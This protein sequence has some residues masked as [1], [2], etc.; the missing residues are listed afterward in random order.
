VRSTRNV[1]EALVYPM[2]IAALGTPLSMWP[3]YTY[4]W[5]T[6]A[7]LPS[8]VKC[9]PPAICI[10]RPVADTMMSASRCLPDFSWMPVASIASI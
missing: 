7:A 2:H 9:M 1:H 8:T 3:R 4:D 10:V 5:G 6:S